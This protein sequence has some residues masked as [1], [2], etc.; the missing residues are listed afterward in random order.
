M[1][2][3][4]PKK[5]LHWRLDIS[6]SVIAFCPF[7]FVASLCKLGL[8]K[9][10]M[11]IVHG[12]LENL[13]VLSFIIQRHLLSTCSM[14]RILDVYYCLACFFHRQVWAVWDHLR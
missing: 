5:E 10:G 3:V 4:K 2:F 7:C 6:S 8:R 14:S 12:L 1:K 9:Q 13:G 11:L